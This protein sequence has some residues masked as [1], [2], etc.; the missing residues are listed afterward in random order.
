M[1]RDP[2]DAGV[3]EKRQ[4]LVDVQQGHVVVNMRA[5]AVAKPQ[6]E[7]PAFRADAGLNA[8]QVGV[9]VSRAL[10]IE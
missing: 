8:F 1:F 5:N 4:M 6:D 2:H 3:V 10:A 7:F 9:S